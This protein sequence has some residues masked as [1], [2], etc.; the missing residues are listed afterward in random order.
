MKKQT[1]KQARILD[2]PDEVYVAPLGICYY[3]EATKTAKVKIPYEEAVERG[4]KPS[5]QYI[6]FLE[7]LANKQNQ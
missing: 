1:T 6:K 3:P 5:R 2:V 7:Q 4:Y